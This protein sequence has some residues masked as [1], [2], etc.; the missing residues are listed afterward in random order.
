MAK[1]LP[2]LFPILLSAA[3]PPPDADTKADV[4]CLV[5]MGSAMDTE[6]PQAKQ[7]AFSTML[8]FLG[9][10]DGR[11]PELDIEARYSSEAKEMNPKDAKAFVDSCI[12]KVQQR[13]AKG[14]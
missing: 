5:A 13:I 8:Y 12:A 4:R 2:F 9:R 7:L 14:L 3:A 11:T 1:L 10:I 6:Q